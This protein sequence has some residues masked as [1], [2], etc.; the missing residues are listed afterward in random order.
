[1]SKNATP[2]YRRT[3]LQRFGFNF[4]DVFVLLFCI[5]FALVCVYPM[6][7]VAV[8]SITPYSEFV[9]GGLMLWPQGGVDLQYYEAIF[10]TK[11]FIHSMWIS[12]SKTVISTVLSVIITATMA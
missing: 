3:M 7:Y 5:L 11:S 6:W 9:K 10:G 8:A 1:M 4:Y 2:K 12:V